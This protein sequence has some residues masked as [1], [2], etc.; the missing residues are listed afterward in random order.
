MVAEV[1]LALRPRDLVDVGQQVLQ[2]AELLEQLGGGLQ[3][4]AGHARDVVR[5]VAGQGQQIDDL[6][7]GHPPVGLQRRHVEDFLLAQVE[8]P[9]V[10]GQQLPGVLVGRADRDV[11]PALLPARARVAIT[12]S[13]STPS[14]IRTGTRNP[15]KT[16][17]M[18]GICGRSSSGIAPRWAL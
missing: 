14:C 12:S 5:R 18:T 15:S 13:A 10:V 8:D 7:G 17:R 2:V 6:L 11:Q 9:D 1:L 3:A 4:D 16:R